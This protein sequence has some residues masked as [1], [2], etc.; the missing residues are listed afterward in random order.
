MP[1]A[2]GTYDAG[3]GSDRWQSARAP[4]CC[5]ASIPLTFFSGSLLVEQLILLDGWHGQASCRHVGPGR[6]RVVLG[7]TAEAAAVCGPRRR[8]AGLK[9][10]N[11][12]SLK[13]CDWFVA[14]RNLVPRC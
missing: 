4:M 1:F 8:A 11:Q 12:V 14:L 2:A 9:S 5:M 10:S 6:G 13:L 7:S 3:G